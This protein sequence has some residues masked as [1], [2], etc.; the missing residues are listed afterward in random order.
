MA[1]TRY[2]RQR[3]AVLKYLQTHFTHPSAE[4]IYAD[5]KKESPNL[6]LGT[7]YRNLALLT[8]TNQIR[9]LDVGEAIVHYDGNLTP[10]QHFICSKC[11]KIYDLD[12]SI[13]E[14][15]AKIEESTGHKVLTYDLIMTGICK[16]CQNK[17]N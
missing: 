7:V 16:D 2:S 6:S 13:D 15:S 4:E 14:L 5:L 9:K 1:T 10:H 11:H 8:E 12:C 3:D 17:D